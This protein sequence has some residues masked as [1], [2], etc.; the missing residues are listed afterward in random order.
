V[1]PLIFVLSAGSDPMAG[2]LQFAEERDMSMRQGLAHIA[3]RVIQRS[4]D[5]RS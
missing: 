1:V 5:P 2:L 3:H 4:L